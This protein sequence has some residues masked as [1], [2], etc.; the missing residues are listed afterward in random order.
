MPFSSKKFESPMV[1]VDIVVFTI[2]A[3]ELAVFLI[4]RKYNPYKG[5]WALPGGFIRKK[6]GPMRAAMRELKEETGVG[7]VYLEQLYTF[8]NPSRDPRGRVITIAYLALVPRH[9]VRLKASFDAADVDIFPIKKL[10]RLAFD[11]AQI[12]SYALT[13]LRNKLQYTNVAWSLMP[14]LFTL[15][16]IQKVYELILGRRIDKRNFRKKILSLGILKEAEKM[17]K[18]LRQRPAQLYQFKTKQFTELRK[19]F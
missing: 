1:T 14:T 11:H 8:G 12:L 7:G 16:E 10:P 13:R 15:G 18:G 19:F 17:K 5:M 6:E 3:Q 2:E 9:T 4:K